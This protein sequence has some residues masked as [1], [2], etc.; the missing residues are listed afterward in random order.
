MVEIG[1]E[2][3]TVTGRRRRPGWLDLVM[4]RHAVRLNSLTEWAITKLDV[5]DTFDVIKVCVAYK[6]NGKEING[7]PDT[8]DALGEVEPVYIEIP[9]WKRSLAGVTRESDLPPSA[10]AL[11]KLIE[12]H[13]KVPVTLVGTGA[14][15]DDL[16]VRK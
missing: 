11:I 1:H 9:G 7:Y 4:L 2:F 10:I 12:E 13:T 5:L 14:G 6:V 3:G 16:L 15:R 8:I